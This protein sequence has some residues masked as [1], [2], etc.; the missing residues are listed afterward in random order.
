MHFEYT[1]KV[2]A[3]QKRLLA[4]MDEYVYPKEKVFY[5]QIA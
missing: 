4:F 3:L 5:Q 2:K 1:D